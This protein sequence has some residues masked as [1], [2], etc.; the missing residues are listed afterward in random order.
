MEKIKAISRLTPVAAFSALLIGGMM[1]SGCS[2]DEP[3]PNEPEICPVDTITPPDTVVPPAPKPEPEPADVAEPFELRLSFVD[4][5]GNDLLDP[6]HPANMVGTEIYYYSEA[7]GGLWVRPEA[8]AQPLPS[9]GLRYVTV[10]SP[11]PSADND[12]GRIST[13][14]WADG[15]H[16]DKITV[17]DADSLGNRYL[18]VN[19]SELIALDDTPVTL[20]SD[21]AGFHYR[22]IEIPFVIVDRLDKI[23]KKPE[24]TAIIDGEEYKCEAEPRDSLN[25]YSLMGL[26]AVF[27]NRFY[28]TDKEPE[29]NF[30]GIHFPKHTYWLGGKRISGYDDTVVLG[31]FPRD[32]AFDLHLTLR[33][34][35]NDMA[36]PKEY[37]VKI[38]NTVRPIADYIR[39]TQKIYVDGQDRS[40]E[41]HTWDSCI[42]LQGI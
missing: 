22:P 13:I 30:T 29:V 4:S 7:V 10:K 38:I 21:D 9:T 14:E 16:T 37:D 5:Q 26:T 20:R 8:D 6:A 34:K 39:S 12:Y 25:I 28:L 23:V 42:R 24:V 19:G 35:T 33:V 27:S 41:Y 17:T 18:S 31:D 1:F 15:T 3:S 40:L 32:K 11:I 36:E 2:D